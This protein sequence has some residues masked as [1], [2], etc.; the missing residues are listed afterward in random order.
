MSMEEPQSI[1][2]SNSGLNMSIRS[3][4][5]SSSPLE[6]NGYFGIVWLN[7]C[8]NHKN[9]IYSSKIIYYYKKISLNDLLTNKY[10]KIKHKIH[11]RL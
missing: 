5:A 3:F 4:G 8:I 9:C 2:K 7:S 6:R 1:K 10:L 11:S